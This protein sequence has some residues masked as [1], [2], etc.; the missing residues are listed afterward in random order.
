M[1]EFSSQTKRLFKLARV[2]PL[3]SANENIEK[4][5]KKKKAIVWSWGQ[6]CDPFDVIIRT[7][8]SLD[9]DK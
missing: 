2:C 1:T 8:L 9:S 3:C 7:I 6:F 4:E 5:R